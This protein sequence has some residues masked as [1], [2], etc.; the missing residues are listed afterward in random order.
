VIGRGRLL[1]QTTVTELA[2][3][4]TSLEDAF[5]ELTEGSTEYSTIDVTGKLRSL[6]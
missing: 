5:F 3:R 6:S 2:A 4:S 1:A